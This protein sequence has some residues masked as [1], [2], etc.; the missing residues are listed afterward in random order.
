MGT[1]LTAEESK[2][3]FERISTRDRYNQVMKFL[4]DTDDFY[5]FTVDEMKQ[6]VKKGVEDA[7]KG[8]GKTSGEM[9]KLHPR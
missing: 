4:D 3:L 5:P 6:I 9:R 2:K 1:V 8:L 7:S